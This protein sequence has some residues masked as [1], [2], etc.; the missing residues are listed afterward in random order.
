MF[1]SP[2]GQ[3]KQKP[4]IMLV[5][6]IVLFI[7][8]HWSHAAPTAQKYSLP[9]KNT[10]HIG[11]MRMIYSEPGDSLK[12]IAKRYHITLEALKGANPGIHNKPRPWSLIALPSPVLPDAKRKGVVINTANR[13][14]YLFPSNSDEVWVFPVAVGRNGWETPVGESKIIDKRKDPVWFVPETIQDAMDEKGIYLPDVVE[15]GPSNPLG[16]YAIRT[17]LSRGT[18]LIHG[19]NKPS[20]IGRPVSSGCVR[21]FNHHVEKVF[22]HVKVGT[23]IQVVHQTLEAMTYP[24]NAKRNWMRKRLSLPQSTMTQDEQDH[25]DTSDVLAG[26]H[27]MM[28]DDEG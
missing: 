24:D 11:E 4:W 15:P 25:L 28:H 17:G 10:R 5:V 9:A 27:Q 8:Y 21:M 22:H 16:K 14:L 26:S 13:R 3:Q 18:I 23:P 20:S 12:A 7:L 19:T 6:G 1:R 2:S